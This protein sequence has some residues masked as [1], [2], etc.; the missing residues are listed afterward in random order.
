VPPDPEALEGPFGAGAETR[1]VA[2]P[3]HQTRRDGVL[4]LLILAPALTAGVPLKLAADET[5]SRVSAR[6][7]ERIGQNR[8]EI[9]FAS[10][11]RLDLADSELRVGVPNPYVGTWIES[12]FGGHVHAAARE[13]LG[14]DARVSYHIDPELFRQ[15]RRRQLESEAR[16]LAETADPQAQGDDPPVPRGRRAGRNGSSAVLKTLDSFVVGNS[17]RMAYTAAC[18]VSR[19]P[20][21]TFNPLF[22]HGSSGVGK[23]H[24]LHGIREGVRRHRRGAAVSYLTAEQFTNQYI[25]AV[26]TRSLDAFRSRYRG[27]DVLII[28]D[29][30]FL[31]HKKGTQEEFLHTFNAIDAAGRQIVMASDA[32]PKLIGE[33]CLPLVNRFLAGLVVRIDAPGVETRCRIV[34]AKAL[35]MGKAVAQEVCHY[36]AER[37]PGN[38]REL[39]GALVSLIA[40]AGLG[41]VKPD[42][43]LAREVLD[44]TLPRQKLVVRSTDVI[45]AVCAAFGV[46]DADLRSRK[47]SRRVVLPRQVA[48]YL[49]RKQM[50]LSAADIGRALGQRSHATVLAAC[51]KVEAMLAENAPLPAGLALPRGPRTFKRLVRQLEQTVTC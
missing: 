5:I 11:T 31:A 46:S 28:D 8:Y 34:E 39:E 41:R 45:E 51:K 38:V 33:I 47:R 49:M 3:T 35:V 7:A 37:V 40:A 23:T 24:L 36:L 44:S 15:S 17:N 19:N 50:A 25:L 20:G 27:Q 29:I 26:Q 1:G 2:R 21:A 6:I 14:D 22:V 30:H 18:E 16:F 10:G 32:H 13:V 12:H 4:V 42:L 9:W 48:M 43:L